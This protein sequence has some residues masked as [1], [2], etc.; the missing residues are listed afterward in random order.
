M[1]LILAYLEIVTENEDPFE[2][3][4]DGG[5]SSSSKVVRKEFSLKE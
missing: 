2:D 4:N 1:T 5:Q 3:A